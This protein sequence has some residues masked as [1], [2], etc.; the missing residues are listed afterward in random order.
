MVMIAKATS[1]RVASIEWL[2]AMSQGRL[3]T[4]SGCT[5]SPCSL[6]LGEAGL[7]RTDD[8]VFSMPSGSNLGDMMGL[9]RPG[10]LALDT[11]TTDSPST[12]ATGRTSGSGGLA[13]S[14]ATGGSVGN[15]FTADFQLGRR[16]P[17]VGLVGEYR[18]DTCSLGADEVQCM[19][20]AG[21]C[22][23]D[24]VPSLSAS[25]S[26]LPGSCAP[27]ASPAVS[28]RSLRPAARAW[29]FCPGLSL[30]DGWSDGLG[31]EKSAFALGSVVASVLPSAVASSPFPSS[32]GLS[33]SAAPGSAG[34]SVQSINRLTMLT[35]GCAFAVAMCSWMSPEQRDASLFGLSHSGSSRSG[36]SPACLSSGENE[37]LNAD[38]LDGLGGSPLLCFMA[39]PTSRE[40]VRWGSP[41]SESY[42][43]A[44][45]WSRSSIVW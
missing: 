24:S 42:P 8:D 30:A 17:S 32:T 13:D 10:E 39:E 43:D 2:S 25:R 29:L 20:V 18:C 28:Q 4:T 15:G 33:M 23:S 37:C 38:G 21:V 3:T 44:C 12:W 6:C 1:S 5:S 41:R 14:P 36:S 40:S 7:K 19:T 22:V 31:S 35:L 34:S 27:S 16:F 11:E 45:F 26:T 9:D